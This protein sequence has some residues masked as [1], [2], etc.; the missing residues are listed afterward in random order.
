MWIL[1]HVGISGDDKE[2][3]ITIVATSFPLF[4]EC[5]EMNLTILS[6]IPKPKSRKISRNFRANILL[7]NKLR[8]IKF[9]IKKWIYPN[10]IIKRD[11]VIITRVIIGYTY[12]ITRFPDQKRTCSNK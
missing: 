1:T 5:N 6:E 9:I 4:K 2:N 11:E 7:M 12:L 3:L 10:D 8:S